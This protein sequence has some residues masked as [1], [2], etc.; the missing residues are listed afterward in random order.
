MVAHVYAIAR[1]PRTFKN[2][3]SSELYLIVSE[4]Y[5]IVSKGFHCI[6]LYLKC[7]S[8][9]LIV[10]KLYLN[11]FVLSELL[12]HMINCVVATKAYVLL[13]AIH[14]F[15]WNCKVLYVIAL[16]FVVV[17]T[18]IIIIITNSDVTSTVSVAK[19]LWVEY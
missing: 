11:R 16:V 17:V 19:L 9:Y 5:L 6:S 14:K 12:C 15:V 1:L 4:V 13:Y 8:L 18:E 7:V 2:N 10:S 3:F